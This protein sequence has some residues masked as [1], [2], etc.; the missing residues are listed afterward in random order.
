MSK[1]D[2]LLKKLIAARK[3]GRIVES[4]YN[5]DNLAY[6]VTI[7]FPIVDIIENKEKI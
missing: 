5:W 2:A 1:I 4:K 6:R 7:E 3:I